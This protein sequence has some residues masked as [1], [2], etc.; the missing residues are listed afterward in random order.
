MARHSWTMLSPLMLPQ[1]SWIVIPWGY[2]SA[3]GRGCRQ[4]GSERCTPTCV[5]WAVT[6]QCSQSL[7]SIRAWDKQNNQTL[8][9]GRKFVC[10]LLPVFFCILLHFAGNFLWSSTKAYGSRTTSAPG[11]L[12]GR[13]LAVISVYTNIRKQLTLF[14]LSLAFPFSRLCDALS[15]RRRKRMRH[16]VDYL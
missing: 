5:S 7:S 15:Y 11:D 12:T 6:K 3:R 14:G 13:H 10:S 4:V 8:L 2:N 16:C 1:L 9:S